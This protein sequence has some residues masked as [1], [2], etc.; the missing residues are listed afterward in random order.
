ML[1]LANGTK[2]GKA[3]RRFTPPTTVYCHHCE[4]FVHGRNE[5]SYPN[6]WDHHGHLLNKVK[7]LTNS[8]R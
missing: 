3:N 4:G 5:P 2:M 1:C 8:G 6:C 7:G